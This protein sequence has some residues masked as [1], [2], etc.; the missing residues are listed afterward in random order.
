MCVTYI[1]NR[2]SYTLLEA[3]CCIDPYLGYY[4]QSGDMFVPVICLAFALQPCTNGHTP[5][6]QG[7]YT[8][9]QT[10]GHAQCVA[11]NFSQFNF[12][13]CAWGASGDC[14]YRV[15]SAAGECL[16][17]TTTTPV[18]SMMTN[19]DK[20]HERMDAKASAYGLEFTPTSSPHKIL[21]VHC[22]PSVPKRLF[23]KV[24]LTSDPTRNPLSSVI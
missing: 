23:F 21:K 4:L 9:Q 22:R 10:G 18:D 5:S 12:A 17:V 6:A 20:L 11:S 3:A 16:P 2:D 7:C 8:C 13:Q 24:A 1:G 15:C 14:S 19:V